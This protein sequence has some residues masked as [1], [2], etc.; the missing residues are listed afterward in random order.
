MKSKYGYLQTN[1]RGA[2]I[3][4]VELLVEM[5]KKQIRQNPEM[6]N[7]SSEDINAII[8]DFYLWD[9]AKINEK[10]MDHLPIHRTRS[11]YY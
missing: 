9:V 8:L 4:A 6:Y 2:S 10:N 1:I 7:I 5:I 3:H 11:I